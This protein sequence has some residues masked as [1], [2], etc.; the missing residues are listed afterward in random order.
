MFGRLVLDLQ[1]GA[2]VPFVGIFGLIKDVEDFEVFLMRDGVV[3]VG[4]TV[5]ASHGRTHPG[6]EGRVNPIG[7][8]DVPEF[9]VICPAL[10]VGLGI[11]MKGGGDQLILRRLGQQISG[12]L[13]DGELI[14]RQVFVKGPD[15][16]IPIGPN[17]ARGIVRVTSGIGIAGQIQPHPRPMF[18]KLGAGQQAVYELLIG[19]RVF[20]R[21]ESVDLLRLRRQADQV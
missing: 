9:L 8:R 6:G 10:V 17:G 2:F 7:H 19:L 14:K 11:S 3:L 20:V 4:M 21:D 12:H 1:K 15:D 13:L 5:R 18:S 16:V